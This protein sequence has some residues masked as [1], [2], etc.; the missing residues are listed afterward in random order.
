VASH[1]L[2]PYLP[3]IACAFLFPRSR[4]HWA[5]WLGV[6]LVA[7]YIVF[8]AITG[9]DWSE[10]RFFAPLVPI[11]SVLG[12][13]ALATRLRD[14][15]GTRRRAVLLAAVATA[16]ALYSAARTG[17]REYAFRVH[18]AADDHERVRIGR[19]L[20]ASAPK[21][22]VL[23]VTAAGQIPYYSKLYTHDMLGL[24]DAHIAAIPSSL[25]AGMP[26]HEKFD[27]SYTVDRVAPD[28]VVGAEWIPGM[29][30]QLARKRA[31]ALLP[32]PHEEILIRKGLVPRGALNAILLATWGDRMPEALRRKAQ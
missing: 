19:W 3:L 2:D 22:A 20:Q 13:G 11:A 30:D 27:V 29:K 32:M 25:G 8:I 9:G 21:D 5:S 15:A 4:S 28:V 23:A 31:Y 17:G 14:A 7:G 10:G 16:F 18:Y 24:N 6:C 1:F 26:G 12:T